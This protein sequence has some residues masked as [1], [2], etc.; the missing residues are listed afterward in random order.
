[1]SAKTVF[2]SYSHDSDEHRE[3]VLALSERLRADGIETLLDQYVNGSPDQG[4]PRWMLDQLDAADSVLVV[5][6]ETYYLRFRGHEVSG[7][8]KGVDWEGAL[9][10]QELY[11]SRS[12]T[13]KFVPVFLSA[14]VED[15]IPEPLRA[16]GHYALISDDAYQYLYNFLLGQA[17]VEP[18]PVGELKPK[19]RR[20]GTPLEFAKPFSSG[21]PT[22][23]PMTLSEEG[24]A[25]A[26]IG[27]CLLRLGIPSY[28]LRRSKLV[29]TIARWLKSPRLIGVELIGLRGI[30]KTMLAAQ[31]IEDMT[32]SFPHIFVVQFRGRV[33]LEPTFF[34]SELNEFVRTLGYGFA[35]D[36]LERQDPQHTLRA[37]AKDF[38]RL[39]ALLVL[40]GAEEAPL[41]WIQI[42][43]GSLIGA[44]GAKLLLTTRQRLLGDDLTRPL[45]IPA[46]TQT[47]A[48]ELGLGYAQQIELQEDVRPLLQKL[49]VGLRTHPQAI[50]SYFGHL[51][52]FPSAIMSSEFS[53]DPLVAPLQF[54]AESLEP[55][56]E[57]SRDILR[58]L[59]LLGG[60]DLAQASKLLRLRH[61]PDFLPKLNLSFA[62]NV[63]TTCLRSYARLFCASIRPPPKPL[64]KTSSNRGSRKPTAS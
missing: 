43:A 22:S 11:D 7:K 1:M 10:T 53:A 56:G 18:R 32:T 63:V 8:G 15:W 59:S 60:T 46:L 3:R 9:I 58:L 25:K 51:L 48:E 12:R 50:V 57:S 5:C 40:D 55:L 42:L 38:R 14:A 49:P 28:G 61:P 31:T 20:K 36:A 33:A 45:A 64:R 19:G 21:M 4:W 62:P 29:E 13:L 23:T 37:L 47:E 54:V 39:D 34:L 44:S 6:T 16:G 27:A 17:G 24:H 52:Y 41:D 35:N 30:G 26:E 2:I